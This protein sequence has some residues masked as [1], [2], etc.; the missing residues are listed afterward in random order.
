M[1]ALCFNYNEA[2]KAH[3][4][5]LHGDQLRIAYLVLEGYDFSE[6]AETLDLCI[7]VVYN[8]FERIC[9]FLAHENGHLTEDDANEYYEGYSD[10]ETSN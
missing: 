6:I 4:M 9:W 1:S 7:D 3:L 2:A 10:I 8:E 5:S